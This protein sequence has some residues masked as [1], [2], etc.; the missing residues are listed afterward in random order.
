[1]SPFGSI[2]DKIFEISPKYNDRSTTDGLG[3]CTYVVI[4]LQLDQS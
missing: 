3:W 1:M 2:F 4:V